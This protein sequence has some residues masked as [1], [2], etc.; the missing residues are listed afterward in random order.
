[1]AAQE[2]VCA[3]ELVTKAN[4]D[5]SDKVGRPVDDG[6]IGIIDPS[7]RMIGLHMYEGL[8]KVGHKIIPA[9]MLSLE[10]AEHL[11]GQSSRCMLKGYRS[12]Y[13]AALLQASLR[14]ICASFNV[15]SAG[16][17]E[18][19]CSCF[20]PCIPQSDASDVSNLC[21]WKPPAISLLNMS[22]EHTYSIKMCRSYLLMTGAS[23]MRPS[24]C[25]WRSCVSRT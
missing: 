24:M 16:V 23:C 15:S 12:C 17:K 2:L 4:G 1:M 13:V 9:A 10:I 14:S 8:F 5:A 21:S 20:P 3:G 18:C 11:I 7:H 25:V 6:Q 19:T 22:N